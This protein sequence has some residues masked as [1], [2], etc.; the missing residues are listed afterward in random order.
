MVAT[1]PKCTQNLNTTQFNTTNQTPAPH[2]NKIGLFH[3][4]TY[5]ICID[6][7]ESVDHTTSPS[8]GNQPR[9]SPY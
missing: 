5:S 4:S 3:Q 9:K 2:I 6:C 8:T 1:L 7:T